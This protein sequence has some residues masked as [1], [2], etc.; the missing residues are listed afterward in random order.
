[1][2]DPKRKVTL[3][4]VR[5][6]VNVNHI[7]PGENQ[8]KKKKHKSKVKKIATGFVA[9]VLSLFFKFFEAALI[10]NIFWNNMHTH[11]MQI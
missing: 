3:D 10:I 7:L 8:L 5:N 4:L 6:K 11:G 9:M 2:D 1:M